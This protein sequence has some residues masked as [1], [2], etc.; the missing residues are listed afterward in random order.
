MIFGVCSL[1]FPALELKQ[2]THERL[3]FKR[4]RLNFYGCLPDIKKCSKISLHVC[5]SCLLII[6]EQE[7]KF[8]KYP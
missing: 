6:P 4:K 3:S 8:Q 1:Y 5:H 7:T 2:L